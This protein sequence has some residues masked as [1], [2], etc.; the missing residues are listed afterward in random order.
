M[1]P[2]TALLFS[3]RLL[4]RP[5]PLAPA[6]VPVP[7]PEPPPAC[8]LPSLSPPSPPTFPLCRCARLRALPM[9]P[10]GSP[11]RAGP[12]AAV[13]AAGAP[14][15]RGRHAPPADVPQRGRAPPHA[16]ARPGPWMGARRVWTGVR[17]LVCNAMC[18]HHDRTLH[19]LAW[20]PASTTGSLA[21]MHP[22]CACDG[23][24]AGFACG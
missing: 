13:A 18:A 10:P 6:P 7:A 5:R 16:G 3:Y 14:C 21:R 15:G 19:A 20:A 11:G 4:P 23:R 9:C 2:H 22:C 1:A 24:A 17:S 8:P 12:H